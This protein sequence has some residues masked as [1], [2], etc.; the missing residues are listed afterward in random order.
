MNLVELPVFLLSSRAP[1]GLNVLEFEVEDF[2]RNL[3]Q[4]VRRQVTVTGSAKYGIPAAAAEKV[5]LALLHHTRAY[6]NFSDP[7]VFFSRGEMLKT[8]KWPN[9]DS[10]YHRLTRCL[11][12]LAGVRLKCVNYWRDNRTKEFRRVTEN[13]AILDY[14]RFRDSRKKGDRD[15]REYLSEF[16]WGSVLFESFDAGYLK[17]LDLNIAMR[18]KPL[19]LR[20]YRL[21]DKN[22]N[23]PKRTTLKYDLRTLAYERLGMSRSYDAAQIRRNLSKAINELAEI[24][25]L[26]P[27]TAANQ[28]VKKEGCRGLWDVTFK[29][30]QAHRQP[31]RAASAGKGSVRQLRPEHRLFRNGR[32]EDPVPTAGRV[33]E[34]SKALRRFTQR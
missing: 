33:F 11:D 14:Y 16:R 29:L 17:R 4:V 8:L 22:F 5:W 3:K 31:K 1:A 23:P 7:Q 10:S 13:I 12:Q 32:F 25:Y 34:T 28:F 9:K 27:M 18:L 21:L 15:F 19:S 30:G 2:D 6:N 26:E 20:L 24:E